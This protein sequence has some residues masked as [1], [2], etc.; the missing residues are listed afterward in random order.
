MLQFMGLQRVRHDLVTEVNRGEKNK[1]ASMKST[2]IPIFMVEL[3][4]LLYQLALL[5]MGSDKGVEER[6]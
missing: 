6:V 5:F 1:Q 2:G 4:D 3:F